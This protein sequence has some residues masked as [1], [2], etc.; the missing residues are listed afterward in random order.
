MTA[1]TRISVRVTPR[2]TRNAIEGWTV[3]GVL[4]VR[5][6]S[7]PTDGKANAAVISIVAEAL[8][9]APSRITLV[10]GA[11]SRAKILAIEGLSTEFI[12]SKLA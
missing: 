11:A 7:A 12:H 4:R 6:T 2:A 3:E 1:A 9:L 8:G 10:S 5:V